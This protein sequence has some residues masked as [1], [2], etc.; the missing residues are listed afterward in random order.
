[1]KIFFQIVSNRDEVRTITEQIYIEQPDKSNNKTAGLSGYARQMGGGGQS[2]VLGTSARHEII[3]HPWE[4]IYVRNYGSPEVGPKTAAYKGY[5]LQF[6][7]R[8]SV[9]A[10]VIIYDR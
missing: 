10:T 1:M 7:V 6:M 3:P 4:W 5:E 9:T 2:F 8:P